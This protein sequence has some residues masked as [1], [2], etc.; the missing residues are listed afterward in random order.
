MRLLIYGA[1][2]FIFCGV[3]GFDALSKLSW[4]KVRGTVLAVEP[5]CEMKSEQYNVLTRTTTTAT[6]DC[7][8]VDAFKI[9]HPD[10]EWSLRRTYLTHLLVGGAQPISTAMVVYEE[11]APR[12]GQVLNLIQDP[13]DAIRVL[14]AN[15]SIKDFGFA[16]IMGAIGL[17]LLLWYAI[18]R[19]NRQPLMRPPRDAHPEPN[20]TEAPMTTRA[21]SFATR[22]SATNASG[23]V[24]GRR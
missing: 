11:P 2:L 7:K 15:T 5:K 24:F 3:I 10:K 16:A 18:R 23:R 19:R 8:A 9:L 17:L 12:A 6:I 1:V 20:A 14:P 21:A 13:N 4:P 22:P